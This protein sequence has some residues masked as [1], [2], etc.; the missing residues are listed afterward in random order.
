[1]LRNWLLVGM[2]YVLMGVIF[3]DY[4]EKK[5]SILTEEEYG[6]FTEKLFFPSL[7]AII[8]GIIMSYIEMLIFGGAEVYIGST[9]IVVALLF[10]SESRGNMGRIL[11]W[12]GK[13]A[14]SMIYYYHV[15]VIAI[16][17][18]LSQNGIIPSYTMW[19]KPILV[20]VICVLLFGGVPYLFNRKRVDEQK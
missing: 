19:Q 16:L 7:A 8:S 17:D 6:K 4:I 10:M 2:P 13:E 3:A 20:M 5:R 11:P 12:L 9:V 1:V 14:S 18:I 15:M